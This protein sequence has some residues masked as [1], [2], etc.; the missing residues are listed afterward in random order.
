MLQLSA[1]ADFHFEILRTMSLSAYEGADIGEVLVAAKEIKPGDFESYSAAFNKL[2][3]RVDSAARAIDARKHPV[4]ARNALFKAANYYRAA[5]FFLHGDWDDA[6]IASLWARQLAAF[7]DAMALLPV[8]GERVSLR[9]KDGD[10]SIPAIF[11]GSGL[12]GRRPTLVVGNGFDGSQEE[13]YHVV[14]Q[15]ALQRGINVVTYEGPGQPTVRREQGLGFIPQ[16]EKVVTPVIDYVVSRPDVDADAVGLLGYSLG[17][18]LA[19]RAAAFEERVAAVLAID[20]VYDFGQAILDNFQPELAAVFRAGNATLFDSIVDAAVADPATQSA[21]RWTVQQGKWSFGVESAYEWVSR[22]AAYSLAGLT[23]NIKA[24]V[25][26]A[27]A[28]NDKFFGGQARALAGAL[29]SRATYHGFE[30]AEG[31][32]QHCSVGASVLGNQV[33][34]DWFENVLS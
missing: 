19:P 27:D 18:F 23:P 7:D 15:A 5:D 11:F 17:G 22:A 26:V 13:M 24:P 2:A 28:Q 9:A 8:P 4:S 32:G 10:F 14:G 20:G 33:W 16:W 21:I 6:R 34:L 1:D 31:A 29:G 30:G 12:P 3:V 25:L